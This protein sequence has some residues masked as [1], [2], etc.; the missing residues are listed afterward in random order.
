M[1]AVG[2][3]VGGLGGLLGGSG[4][5]G[6]VLGLGSLAA[7]FLGQQKASRAADAYYNEQRRSLLA[8]EAEAK[9]QKEE[10]DKRARQ[11]EQY[12]RDAARVEAMR[13]A[14]IQQRELRGRRRGW[15]DDSYYG[16]LEDLLG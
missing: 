6:T 4:A 12:Q 15:F 10:M 13:S 9:K 7:G 14:R 2:A 3:L 16:N 5:L 8:Q 11:Q 1:G